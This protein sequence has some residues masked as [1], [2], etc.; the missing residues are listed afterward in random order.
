MTRSL[1]EAIR[2]RRSV[3]SFDPDHVLDDATLRRMFELVV[4]TPSSFNLQHWRFVVVRD[5]ARRQELKAASFGQRH[6]G[7]GSAVV[8]VCA[9]L[10]AHEDAA[11]TNAHAPPDVV[12]RLVPVIER[13]YANDPQFRR[14]EAIRSAS[15]ASMTLMLVAE[16]LGLA[17]CPMIGFDPAKVSAVAGLDEGHIPVMLIVLG[18]MGETDP[19]PTSRLPLAEVVKQEPLTGPGL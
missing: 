16:S 10:A 15:L 18:K 19:F 7:E 14:D 12:K 2:S 1:E 6:V 11:R 13:Y 4:E 8:V 5:H 9:K 17:T 3:K